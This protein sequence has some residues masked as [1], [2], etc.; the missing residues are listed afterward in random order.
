[1][2][3]LGFSDKKERKEKLKNLFEERYPGFD[4]ENFDESCESIFRDSNSQYQSGN[5][6]QQIRELDNICSDS[7]MGR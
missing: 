4:F 7:S 1:M 5:Y 2:V 3:E 6:S